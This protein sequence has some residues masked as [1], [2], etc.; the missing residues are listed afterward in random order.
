[1]LNNDS[2]QPRVVIFAYGNPSRGDDALG[3]TLLYQLTQED[4]F[5][6]KITCIEDFQLQIEHALDLEDKDLALFIDASVSCSPPFTF[7]RLYPV[8]DDTFTSHALHPAAILYTYQRIKEQ[9]PPPAF[10]LSVRGEQFELGEPLSSTAQV[11]LAKAY[12]FLQQL[13][14]TP[15]I[16]AWQRLSA[17]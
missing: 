17:H 15:E 1:M 3:P 12:A 11:H 16:E 10:L 7:T 9:A 8:R 2:S 5:N 13:C 6:K 14:H 4:T